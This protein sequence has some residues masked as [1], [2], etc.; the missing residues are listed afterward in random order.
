MSEGAEAKEFGGELCCP[1]PPLADVTHLSKKACVLQDLGG[2]RWRELN[3]SACSLGDCEGMVVDGWEGRVSLGSS[4]QNCG[5]DHHVYHQ[6]H[7]YTYELLFALVL[8]NIENHE[9][10]QAF[11]FVSEH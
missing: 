10:P 11:C 8:V 6:M 4:E 5:D 3:W 2:N 9:H 1:F 7:V